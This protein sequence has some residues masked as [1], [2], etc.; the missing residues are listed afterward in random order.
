MG[1]NGFRVFVDWWCLSRDITDQ[2]Q[3][4]KGAMSQLALFGKWHHVTEFPLIGCSG[5]R[6]RVGGKPPGDGRQPAISSH[7]RG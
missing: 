7:T 6:V 2:P 4:Q 5:S 1:R 3:L